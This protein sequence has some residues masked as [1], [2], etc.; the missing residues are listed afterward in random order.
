V[1][2]VAD[3]MGHQSS[4]ITLTTYASLWPGDEDRIR[5][6]IA[7]AWAHPAEDWLRTGE[8]ESAR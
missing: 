3:A 1:K 4:T 7:T 6:A 8:G 5:Q 2:A